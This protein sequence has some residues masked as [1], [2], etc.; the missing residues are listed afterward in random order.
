[1][2]KKLKFLNELQH[3]FSVLLV[4]MLLMMPHAYA[5][6]I[7]ISTDRQDIKIGEQIEYEIS[8]ETP[9]SEVVQFPEGQSFVPLELVRSTAID[10]F[11]ENEKMRLVKRFFLTQ[12]DSGAYTIP[13]QRIF[14]GGHPQ[15]TD[16]VLVNVHTVPV[17]TLQQPLYD[18][19]TMTQTEKPS[20]LSKKGWLALGIVL[21]LALMA[22]LIYLFVFRAK[23]LTNEEKRRKLPPFERAIQDLRNLQNSKYLIES[24]H[25]EYYSELTDIVREYLEDEVHILAKESTTDELLENITLRQEAGRLN[26]TNETVTNL[27]QVLRTAD[28][29]KFARNKPSD[30]V[31]E[32]DRAI[33]EDVVVK[34]KEALPEPT[35]EERMKNEAYLEAL[36]A[37]KQKQRNRIVRL[38]AAGVLVLIVGA[39]IAFYGWNNLKDRVLGNYTR[40]LYEGRWVDSHYGFPPTY[41]AT[42]E[43]LQRV[44]TYNIAG[45][46]DKIAQQYVFDFG[47]INSD[48]YIMTSVITFKKEDPQSDEKMTIDAD[49]VNNTI[50][51]LIEKA[52]GQNITTL[53]EEYTT[54]KG[55]KGIKLFGKMTLNNKHGK[56]FQAGYE[57]YSFTENGALQ[58]LF[59]TYND[60]DKMANEIAE[61]IVYSLEF[62][63]E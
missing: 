34:T 26:L 27:K 7:R 21:V 30:A 6:E 35:V 22:L 40:E 49:L 23:K 57:L 52:G 42:P 9:A 15:L 53:S 47:S 50:L 19:K 1:M 8:V 29:V 63:T 43:A 38:S 39:F 41:L 3:R 44:Q 36:A 25:K 12:F 11:R 18:I 17:D 13:R 31:A 54:S 46:E 20:V 55:A 37:K 4:G 33:I 5:Q 24:R 59:I 14:I 28:L 61:R 62:K 48:L 60:H 56:P 10:T 58:Q 51:R 16:S 2:L 45:Y 32:S